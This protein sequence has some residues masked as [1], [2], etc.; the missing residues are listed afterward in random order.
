MKQV[1]PR[2]AWTGVANC[3]ACP[4]RKN[5]LFAS[6]T[7]DDFAEMHR[8]IDQW[9]HQPGSV[10]YAQGDPAQTVFTLRVGLVKLVQVSPDGRQRIVR[11]VRP[12]DAFGLEATVNDSYDH[13]AISLH[14]S[15]VCRIS[16]KLIHDM[17]L[18]RP[19]LAD[20]LLQHWHRIAVALARSI[21][22]FNTGT[23][24][25]RIARLMHWLSNDTDRCHL[26]GREDVG[27]T[28]G[29]TTETVSRVVAELKRNRV[30]EE[31]RHNEFRIDVRSIERLADGS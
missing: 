21:T 6:L 9:Q 22:D 3:Q 17:S 30:I 29:L 1:S 2:D 24:R 18:T 28:L 19:E 20:S 23:A 5:A 11:L 4:I 12:T 31:L 15:Q 13:S 27:A 14:E 26:F 16:A 7:A 25:Q 10:I 8:P